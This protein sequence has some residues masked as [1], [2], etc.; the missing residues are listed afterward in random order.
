MKRTKA[1][2]EYFLTSFCNTRIKSFEA[3]TSVTTSTLT[4]TW[5]ERDKIQME[6]IDLK[7]ISKISRPQV[8]Q[9]YLEY[10]RSDRERRA[11]KE[12]REGEQRRRAEKERQG[13][14]SREEVAAPRSD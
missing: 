10:S 7:S 12:S 4:V 1:A 14:E 3:Y 8:N 13:E 2:S 6:N 9:V 11:E 5:R